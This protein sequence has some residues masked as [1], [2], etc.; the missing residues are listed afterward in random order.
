VKGGAPVSSVTIRNFKAIRDSGR[1]DFGWL[2]VFIGS[3]GS[4]KS[5]AIEALETV[6]RLALGDLDRA[7]ISFRGFEHVH[8]KGLKRDHRS[9]PGATR[10]STGPIGVSVRGNHLGKG[11]SASTEIGLRDGNDLYLGR[12]VVRR[13]TIRTARTAEEERTTYVRGREPEV[14]GIRREASILRPSFS[15]VAEEWQFVRLNV[16]R[17][18]KPRPIRRS[19]GRVRL[20]PHGTN[21]AEYLLELA[22]DANALDCLVDAMKFVLPYARN[23]KVQILSEI[24]RQAYLEMA[25][26]EFNVPGW[27]LS[28]GTLR[29][30]ALLALFFHPTPPRVLLIEE[31]ENGLDPRTIGLIVDVLRSAVLHKRQ[32]VILTTHSPYLLDLFPLES[33]VMV[34]RRDGASTFWRPNDDAQVRKWKGTFAP[35]RL[36]TTGSFSRGKP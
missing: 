36:Y 5:S 21:V 1:L 8:Y 27:M 6:K 26:A 34:D 4:G 33:I 18:S 28:T 30:A 14:K 29:V 25:E 31:L 35:G 2:T 24:E 3:N 16:D 9:A 7:M 19:A 12:E 13:G 11:F 20:R 17:M 32:Q 10:I 23:L 15:D 22:R